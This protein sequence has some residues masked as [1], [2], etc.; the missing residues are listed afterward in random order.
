[1][2]LY[3]PSKQSP[4]AEMH[5]YGSNNFWKALWK[6]VSLGKYQKSQGARSGL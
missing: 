2:K 3:S 6:P 1:M 4:L 5:L